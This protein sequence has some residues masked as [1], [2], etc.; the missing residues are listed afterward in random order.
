MSAANTTVMTVSSPTEPV[1][2]VVLVHG[3]LASQALG[4]ALI[5]DQPVDRT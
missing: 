5:V 1:N 4:T 3:A 2:V